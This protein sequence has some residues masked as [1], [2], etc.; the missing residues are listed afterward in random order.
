MLRLRGQ[1]AVAVPTPATHHVDMAQNRTP[2]GVPTGGQF[3]QTDHSEADI[4]LTDP[5]DRPVTPDD[6]GE[7]FRNVAAGDDYTEAHLVSIGYE[8][9][10]VSV[11]LVNVDKVPCFGCGQTVTRSGPVVWVDDRTGDDRGSYDHQHGCGSWNAPV[12][13]RIEIELDVSDTDSV[14]DTIEAAMAELREL[15]TADKAER[16]EAIVKDLTAKVDEFAASEGEEYLLDGSD[17]EPG[18]WVNDDGQVEAWGFGPDDEI[19][20]VPL[21]PD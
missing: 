10:A 13:H 4:D 1:L 17:T 11:E 15:V 7:I 12:T 14:T 6:V 20:T 9:H 2:K 18:L 3:A 19:I 21:P 5:A 8:K 16:R